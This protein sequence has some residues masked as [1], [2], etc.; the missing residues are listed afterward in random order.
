MTMSKMENV[1]RDA[2]RAAGIGLVVNATLV[3]IK[4]VGGVWTGSAALMADAVNSMGDVASSIVV[5]AALWVAQRDA[6]EDHPYGHTKAESIAGLTVALLIVFS[7]GVL[8]VETV[9]T[10]GYPLHA[11]AAS[12]AWVSL[13]VALI[14]ESLYQY[15]SRTAKRLQSSALT[16]AAWDHRSDALGSL[17]IAIALGFA[18]WLG[19]RGSLI[20]PIAALIVCVVLVVSGLRVYARTAAELMDQQAEAGIVE[21]IAES[22]RGT[23]KVCD[24]EKLRVRK[25]GL[26]FF[27]EI[28]VEIDGNLTVDE[29]HRVGHCVKDAIMTRFPRV[30][31]V[32]VH[33]EPFGKRH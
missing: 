29:G 26:E 3:V 12:A 10:I 30:R 31:D 14:K 19:P 16:A 1:Y 9:R 20:D 8:A 6:D 4:V 2:S 17:G 18:Q 11:A 25:S 21:G 27:V 22:A 24:I 23:D 15:T 28:H 5:R 33:V 7:A 13:A 32:H